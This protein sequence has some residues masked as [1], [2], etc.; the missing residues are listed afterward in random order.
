M[1]AQVIV[2]IRDADEERDPEFKKV[3]QSIHGDVDSGSTLADAIKKFPGEFSRS[4]TELIK[5]AE[6]CGAWDEILKEIT[7]GL[8][9]GTFE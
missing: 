1:I 8:A 2:G 6:K 3:L 5:T 4:I 7:D 9:E